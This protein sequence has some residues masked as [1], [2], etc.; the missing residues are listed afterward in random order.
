MAKKQK[1]EGVIRVTKFKVLKPISPIQDWKS[2]NQIIKKLQYEASIASNRVMTMCNIY[3]S[4]KEYYGQAYADESLIKLYN[5][6]LRNQLYKVASKEAKN[7]YSR[8]ANMLSN[9]IFA[10]YFTGKNS[11]EKNIQKGEGNPPMNFSNE[12]AIPVTSQGAEI[13]K[14]DKGYYNITFPLISGCYKKSLNEEYSKEDKPLIKDCKFTFALEVKKGNQKSVIE[15]CISG[16]YKF[17]DSKIAMNKNSEGKQELC[18]LLTYLQP[19]QQ[20]SLNKNKVCGVDLGIKCPAVLAVNYSNYSRF[21]IKDDSIIDEK[22]KLKNITKK[23]QNKKVTKNM[24]WLLI[25]G[26]KTF[27]RLQKLSYRGVFFEKIIMVFH[28]FTILNIYNLYSTP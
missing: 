21:Y 18:V 16:E 22:I 6:N 3:Y 13:L 27:M 15:K 20:L 25:I 24:G 5:Q 9:D 14:T 8:N 26:I 4:E 17:C 11:Y 12:M 28:P 10:K 1:Q 2:L 19:I 23:L 7:F